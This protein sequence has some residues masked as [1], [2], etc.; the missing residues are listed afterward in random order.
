MNA[1]QRKIMTLAEVGGLR[2]G[3]GWHTFRYIYRS[4]LEETGGAAIDTTVNIYGVTMPDTTRGQWK[5]ICV[6]PRPEP[7]RARRRSRKNYCAAVE[8]FYAEGTCSD[9]ESVSHEDNSEPKPSA[10]QVP[11]CA[12]PQLDRL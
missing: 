2:A 8:S 7:F 4:Q 10:N 6:I 12:A 9:Y 3:V 5:G 1:G 11:T